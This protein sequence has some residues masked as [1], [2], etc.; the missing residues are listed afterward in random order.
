MAERISGF[1]GEL[2]PGVTGAVGGARVGIRAEERRARARVAREG[3][4]DFAAPTRSRLRARDN[5]PRR[6]C[7]LRA[8]S[9]LFRR[10]H[11][12]PSRLPSPARA[13]AR[14]HGTTHRV[15]ADAQYAGAVARLET[16]S[17]RLTRT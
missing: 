14:T 10:K 11:N 8:I 2:L 17:P 6:R 7:R 16:G 13:H 3:Q 15:H 1:R 9:F 4:G 5:D 12:N